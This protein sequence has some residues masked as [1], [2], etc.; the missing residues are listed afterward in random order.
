MS[1]FIP[2]DRGDK[3][4]RMKTEVKKNI[5][6]AAR[7]EIEMKNRNCK[8]IIIQKWWRRMVGRRSL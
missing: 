7:K 3:K 1:K 4:S 2:Q 6:Q 8:A 5:F